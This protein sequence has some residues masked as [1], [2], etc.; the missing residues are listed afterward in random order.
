M[1]FEVPDPK[2]FRLSNC[3]MYVLEKIP[4]KEGGAP[5]Y[6]VWEFK[7]VIGGV[8]SATQAIAI[9]QAREEA[10]QQEE[11]EFF[12]STRAATASRLSRPSGQTPTSEAPAQ[13]ESS[14]RDST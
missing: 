14:P 10:H 5:S 13:S 9:I 2:R 8:T 3:G 4:A 1:Q 7:R 12:A 11:E 6:V